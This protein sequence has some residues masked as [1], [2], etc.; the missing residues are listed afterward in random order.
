MELME[1]WTEKYNQMPTF[2]LG[3]QSQVFPQA[4]L[5][6]VYPTDNGVLRTIVPCRQQVFAAR[7]VRLVA[8]K[9][10][11][12]CSVRFSGGPGN[13][14]IRAGY[15][16]FYSVVQGVAGLRSARNLPMDLSYT[17]PAPPLFAT[18]FITAADGSFTGIHFR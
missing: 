5:G 6:V 14:S 12:A 8:R 9:I 1:Y 18:P 7:G 4:P 2:V 11:T 17:S 13:T 10:R 15:G 3:Q 16:M